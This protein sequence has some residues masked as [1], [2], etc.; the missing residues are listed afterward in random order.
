MILARA[1]ADSAGT[2]ATMMAAMAET[3]RR[4]SF[5]HPAGAPMVARLEGISKQYG[6][7]QALEK[8]VLLLLLPGVCF[9]GVRLS[10]PETA[11]L[12]STL[13]AGSGPFSAM[14]LAIGYFIGPNSAPA[15][16]N[17]IYL[18]LSF[19]SGLGIPF[20]FLPRVVQRIA[21]FLPP[22]HLA[23]LAL[24]ILHAG[25]Q[26]SSW[27]HWRIL[28]GFALICLGVARIGFQRDEAKMYG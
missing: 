23:Q 9:G 6:E 19:A 7:V 17:L 16:I 13:V 14:G 15:V 8:V 22:Y 24:D 25:Q 28:I 26:E 27:T 1:K 18:P 21:V 20:P 2:V 12:A 5:H 3:S 4:P 11:K 10:L